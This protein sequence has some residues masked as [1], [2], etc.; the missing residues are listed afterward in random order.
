VAGALAAGA[1]AAGGVALGAGVSVAAP[2]EVTKAGVVTVR[3]MW[4]LVEPEFPASLTKAAAS[5]A[6]ES[7]HT[8]ATEMIG[9]FQFGDAARRVRAAA[10]QRRHQ[11]WSVCSGA[12]H[13]GHESTWAPAPVAPAAPVDRPICGSGGAEAP[14]TRSP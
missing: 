9:A 12:P 1:L 11:S 8:T 5:T 2:G 7:A 4:I 13:S 3:A 14:L 6:S 10:P